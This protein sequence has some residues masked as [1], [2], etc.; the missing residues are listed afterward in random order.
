ME[1]LNKRYSTLFAMRK[2][3][4]RI[5]F[6]GSCVLATSFSAAASEL[7]STHFI[8]RDPV[9][10]MGGGFSS[11]GTFKLF[12]AGDNPLGD[13]SSTSYQSRAGF[14]QYPSITPSPLTPSI[15]GSTIALSWPAGVGT[16][17]WN[18]S[19]YNIG[20]ASDSGGPYTYTAVGAVTSYEYTDQLPG[21]YYLILQTLDGLGNVIAT[22]DEVSVVVP[23]T[24]SFSISANSISFGT[25]TTSGAR[26][27][28]TSN[29]SSSTT[30]AHTLTAGTNAQ[31][32]YSLTYKGTDFGSDSNTI[33]P[34]VIN[35]SSSGD[36]GTSQFALS[37]ATNGSATITSSYDQTSNNWLYVPNSV[38]T[39]A[40]TNE[41][42]PEEDL[43]G[44]YIANISS[45]TASGEYSNIITYTLTANF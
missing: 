25:L 34:A 38:V 43:E 27:A 1:R 9:F 22:S 20:I 45:G 21:T 41:P 24:V 2:N 40:T 11:S 5:L 17:G 32:G 39:V 44:Y 16:N 29:G 15:N 3:M 35:G 31:N 10:D 14:L 6:I 8:V 4:R 18:V 7:S 36:P 23:E 30:Y 19:G 28:T 33:D 26:Y 13:A 12:S 37:F 42:T